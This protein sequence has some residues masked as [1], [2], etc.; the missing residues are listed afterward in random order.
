MAFSTTVAQKGI[1]S[2]Y[3]GLILAASDR[4]NVPV[5]L[6]KAIISQESNWIADAVNPADPSYGLM[7]LNARYWTIGG[8]PIFDPAQNIDTGTGFLADLIRRYGPDLA[9]V[10]SAYN[11]GHPITGNASYVAAVTAFYNWFL[12]ND[13]ASGGGGLPVDVPPVDGGGI[14]I[15]DGDIRLIAGVV[16]GVMLVFVLLR[17]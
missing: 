15:S 3:E 6:I 11:A 2:P 7:Q 9:P 16:V 1:N 12:Q 5:A 8:Q 4:H 13:P 14:D 10:I 17:R